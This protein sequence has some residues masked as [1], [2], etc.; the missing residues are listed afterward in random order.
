MTI[1][2]EHFAPAPRGNQAFPAAQLLDVT[3]R[4]GSFAVGFRWDE[5]SVYRIVGALAKARIPFVELGYLGGV[6][7]LHHVADAGITADFPLFLAADL[8]ARFPETN[9]ALMVHPGALTREL[10]YREIRQAGIALL[11]FVYHPSWSEKLQ[12]GVASARQAGL[13]T[14]V[15]VAL[16]TR[17]EPASLLTLCCELGASLESTIYLADTCSSFYP[18]QVQELMRTLAAALPVPLG[19]HSHD[20]MSLAFANSLAA[21]SAGATYIDVSLSGIGRGAG[22]LA[23]ELWCIAAVAQ[24]V[25]RYDVEALLAGLDE[26]RCYT[27]ARQS[28]V[29]SLVCGACNLTP[30]EEDLLRHTA[31]S[32]GVNGA[33]LACRYAMQ[34]ARLPRLSSETL[35]SLLTGESKGGIC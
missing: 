19:F 5:S 6:P 34:R 28:D 18:V 30:P 21:A 1:L 32:E 2:A 26:V 29:V 13:S 22:N 20:F 27:S 14:T 15:N 9:F 7:D 16:A 8:A 12:Q 23:A 25:E 17:Y 31:S 33:V 24:E 35:L 10:D 11:R 3:L 4:D